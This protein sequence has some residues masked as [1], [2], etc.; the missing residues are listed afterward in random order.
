MPVP[1]LP[2]PPEPERTPEKVVELLA[3]P[4]VRLAAFICT[5]PAPLSAPRAFVPLICRS[6]VAPAA[7]V[8][9]LPS[10]SAPVPTATSV[11]AS[12]LSLPA[13]L[14]PLRVSVPAPVLVKPPVPVSAPEKVLVVPSPPAVRVWLPSASVPDP[15]REPTVSSASPSERVAPVSML[16]RAPSASEAPPVSA[17]V[18]AATVVAPLKLLVP[19]RVSVPA[20]ALVNEPDPEIA[21]AKVRSS[22]RSKARAALLVIFPAMLP[23]A[24]PAPICSVPAEMVVPPA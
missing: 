17:S 16:R 5:L 21:P 12:T 4:A 22:E 1:V 3:L 10:A 8:T 6:S 24:P 15:A 11:P 20:P 18:P 2:K 9:A 13:P 23:V 19:A 14:L 7:T